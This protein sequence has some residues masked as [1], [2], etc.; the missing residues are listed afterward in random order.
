LRDKYS[1]NPRR[2]NVGETPLIITKSDFSAPGDQWQ[3]TKIPPLY[4]RQ[5][6]YMIDERLHA[7]NSKVV[8]F[9]NFAARFPRRKILTFAALLFTACLT[10]PLTPSLNG[11]MAATTADVWLSVDT[12]Q[13]NLAVMRGEA[14]LQVFQNIAIGRNGPSESRQRGDETTPLGE[15][16]IT[17]IRRSKRFELFM[18]INYPNLDH[19]ERAFQEHRIDAAEYKTL[20]YNLDQ[21]KP[22]SQ[23]T[24]LGGQ[25]GIHGLGEGDL[26]VHKAVNWTD[27]CIALTNEQLV[28]L[29]DWVAVGTRVVVR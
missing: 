19:T 24:S 10:G 4:H 18:A 12:D 20:R 5:A 29:A 8:F 15:F 1:I 27:G 9:H 6:P 26:E 13:L 25:L 3:I 21:G 17:E 22:P 16:T 23:G 2:G 11:A 7:W 14:E 28:E